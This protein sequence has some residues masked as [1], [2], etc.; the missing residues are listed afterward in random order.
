MESSKVVFDSK[1]VQY[2]LE[3]TEEPVTEEV[4]V[5]DIKLPDDSPARMKTLRAEGKKWYL[6]VV[7]HDN[8][9]KPFA[10]FCRTNSREK[11]VQTSDAVERLL[12]LAQDKG[13]L[14]D[15][16]DSTVDKISHESNVDK[17]TRVISLLLRHGVAI[18]NIVGCL[19]KM[20]DVFVGSFLFQIRKFLSQ[21]IQ[22]GEEVEGESCTECGGKVVYS[23]GCMKCLDC[24]SSKCG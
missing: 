2:K 19:E 10:L 8:T 15:H 7:Y 5:T 17:L 1:I 24:G 16:I 11:S 21:Y 20:E 6:T 23:E 18:K 22:D 12:Q 13:I 14:K 4:V 9:E 3:S